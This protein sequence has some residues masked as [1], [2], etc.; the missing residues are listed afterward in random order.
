MLTPEV[1]KERLKT[2]KIESDDDRFLPAIE[3]L[4][5]NLRAVAYGLVGRDE[6][7][8]EFVDDERDGFQW[9]K[10]LRKRHE[11]VRPLA[12]LS[13]KDRL[14]IYRLFF[15]NSAP[16]VEQARQAYTTLP[17][18]SFHAHKPFRA[19]HNAELALDSFI[20]WLIKLID[21]SRR[22]PGE[23]LTP[24]WLA[25]WAPHLEESYGTD[26]DHIGH[27]LSAV[28]DTGGKEGD[29]VFE[30]L[31]QSLCNEH[32][33]G[34]MGVHITRA[35]L[36]S[37][38]QEG[39]ELIEKTL[40]AAQRQEGLRQSILNMATEA[41]PEAFRRMLRLVREHDLGRF[42][43]V[44]QAANGWFGLA[45][46]S[47]SVGVV[48][49]TFDRAL[50][51]LDDPAL[52]TKTL[53]GSDAED[54]HLALWAIAFDDAFEAIPAAE[55]LIK[56]KKAEVRFVAVN[57]LCHLQLP[58]T[59]SLRAAALDDDDLRVALC[60]LDGVNSNDE[61][62]VPAG[63]PSNG[64]GYFDRLERLFQRLPPKPA[65]L[66]PLV[67]PWTER[68]A[69]REHVAWHLVSA[70]GKRAPTVLIPYLPSIKTYHRRRV[71][72][73][74][75]EQ[76]KWDA[77]TRE[78]LVRL[79]GDASN[80]VRAEACKSLAKVKLTAEEIAVL[81]GFLTRKASDL[82]QGIFVLLLKLTD[83]A[84]LASADRLTASKDAQQRLAGLE[85]LRQLSEAKR[86][87]A[88]W[89]ERAA[90]FRA[91]RTKLS[92]E[93]ETQL[94]ALAGPG[95]D[96]ITLDNAL[97]LMDSAERSPVVAPI[98][99]K[100]QF[101]TPAALACIQSLDDLI[102]EHRETTI[103][104]KGYAGMQREL[105]G[106][107]RYGFPRPE[108]DVPREKSRAV[109]PLAELWEKWYSDR[110]K[111]L[112]DEDGLEL[113][114][115]E[116]WLEIAE[117]D[118]DWQRFESWAKGSAERKR[119]LAAITGGTQRQKLRYGHLVNDLVNW[120]LYLHPP[121]SA[122][123][124]L[125][126]AAEAA[127]ALVPE[128]EVRTLTEPRKTT[129]SYYDED[130]DWRNAKVFSMWIY[131]YRWRNTFSREQATRWWR[132]LHWLDEPIAGAQ[133]DRP[134]L[135][136]VMVGY[137]H[138]VATL[139]DIL[140]HLLGPGRVER[141]GGL[142]FGT[143][144]TLTARKLDKTHESFL[145]K[146]AEVRDAVERCRARIVEI[147]LARGEMPTGRNRRCVALGIVMGNR[148]ACAIAH[149][150]RGQES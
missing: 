80:D 62:A 58:Q 107:F 148:L 115:A 93:E 16:W 110:A 59:Q 150:P 14:K 39:W 114:R 85:I 99:R 69:S 20:G 134:D 46:D 78:T 113:L 48:N 137:E 129:R 126:D 34:C 100:V 24:A 135:S 125:L 76:K 79:A 98:A 130:P 147:E 29:E 133:R 88:A 22:Y 17:Y 19:P 84:A 50:T 49:K 108:L 87:R 28:I 121:Q 77:V 51:M 92:K 75:G 63:P 3:A 36:T 89:Q 74:L 45:W 38:R 31:R 124:F 145:A 128:A 120:M 67:W 143:L 37:S 117:N 47:I 41:H 140:D 5:T 54:I 101:F 144:A 81:E 35:L 132:L 142:D 43:A 146:H 104:Y 82:R 119:V 91:A 123:D 13:E 138:G 90:A 7:G 57:H 73:M 95:T 61:D 141:Y 40:L 94:D 139:A 23:I 118:W 136:I 26:Q 18:Q 1:A 2:W 25:A 27:L 68:K 64:K 71:V 12:G 116:R 66:K 97:G 65:T 32:E 44:V 11:A 15:G 10:L 33:I 127:T 105:L 111:S 9:M 102:H 60:A 86:G 131:W 4:S 52:R 8:S 83:T 30:I 53:A 122:V 56:H 72:E 106:N 21:I 149:R 6:K 112:R 55:N 109:L 42:S 70:L 96:Q 103:E